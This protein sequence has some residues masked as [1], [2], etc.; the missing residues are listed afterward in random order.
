MYPLSVLKPRSLKSI[1]LPT[2][3]MLARQPSLEALG[4]NPFLPF[5]SFWWLP[6]SLGPWLVAVSLQFSR[7]TYSNLSLLSSHCLCCVKTPPLPFLMRI[8]VITF[9]PYLHNPIWSPHLKIL[10]AIYVKIYGFQ[11]LGHGY[12]LGRHFLACQGSILWITRYLAAFL[13]LPTRCW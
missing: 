4:G 11:E 10:N 5:S 9:R 6:A 13:P 7:L 12:L 1:S 8:S 3:K 2:I